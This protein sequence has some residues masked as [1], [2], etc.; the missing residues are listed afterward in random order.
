[1]IQ[2]DEKQYKTEVKV[3]N[4]QEIRYRAYYDMVYVE[5]PLDPHYQR[6][7]IFV[8]EAYYLGESINGYTAET[9]PIFMPNQVGGYM[10]GDTCAPDLD[11]LD[12]TRPNTVFAALA[13]GYVVSVPAIRGR[14]LKDAEGNNIGK[15]P[16]L[17]VDL[18]AAVR[19]LRLIAE[20]IPGD[21]EKII[22]NGTSAGGALSSLAGATGDHPD[23]LPYLE[24][25]GAADTSDRI[26]AAS[27]YCPITNL[28]HAD[29][30]YE[31]QFDGVYDFHR[32][33][34]S[35]SEGNRPVFSPID[36][37]MSEEERRVSKEEAKLFPAYVNGLDL[38]DENGTSLTL[39]E[40]G[41]GTF[42]EYIKK[43]VLISAGRA[44]DAGED[45]SDKTYLTIEQGKAVGIDFS[46]YVSDITRM[47]NAPAFDA[48]DLT[49]PENDEFGNEKT[50]LMHF[51]DYSQTNSTVPSAM[52]DAQ[53]IRML[54]PM[55]YI[56][57]DAAKKAGYYRIRHGSCDRDT[58]LAISAMLNLKLLEQRVRVDYHLPWGRPHSGDYDLPELFAWIDRIC[59]D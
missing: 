48:L 7:N 34:M 49:S 19:F 39:D 4:G 35:M 13:H 16:A 55:N 57:D 25:I 2:F 11:R 9:A 41:Q 31:W 54:N 17:I 58:S 33:H 32:M 59:K 42:L 28:E 8:P 5:H 38:K 50:D 26:F 15:A 21:V 56:G 51:T 30:A 10:P 53:I 52:A 47:K 37:Q 27:C 3:L 45:L 1:M 6:M 18:K 23:Y 12:P 40:N 44:L 43:Q 46:A 24:K 14:S 29:M 20:K 36:G 22:T